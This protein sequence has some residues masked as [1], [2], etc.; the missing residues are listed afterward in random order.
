MRDNKPELEKSTDVLEP[1]QPDKTTTSLDS[2][3]EDEE[4]DLTWIWNLKSTC[5]LSVKD[6][7]ISY[8]KCLASKL[9]IIARL[10]V[11]IHFTLK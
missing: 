4:M 11:Y 8:L 6:T 2:K 7:L 3:D 10:T 1:Q 5:Q 9:V